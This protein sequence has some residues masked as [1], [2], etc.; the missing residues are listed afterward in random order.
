[1]YDQNLFCSHIC[2]CSLTKQ[3]SRGWNRLP[4]EVA[5]IPQGYSTAKWWKQTQGQAVKSNSVVVRTQEVFL[6]N[7][8][9]SV[10]ALPQMTWLCTQ[11]ERSFSL[12]LISIWEKQIFCTFEKDLISVCLFVCCHI[13]CCL[14][15]VLRNSLSKFYVAGSSDWGSPAELEV[16]DWWPEMNQQVW[17]SIQPWRIFWGLFLYPHF[18]FLLYTSALA[19]FSAKC[20]DEVTWVLS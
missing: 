4:V 12:G 7:F 16:M 17:T 14:S 20:W 18:L 19:F 8:R 2:K 1:M 5:N 6:V 15:G 9:V 3:T 10:F 13:S 11:M